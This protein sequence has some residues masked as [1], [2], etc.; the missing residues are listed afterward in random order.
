MNGPVPMDPMLMHAPCGFVS[1][2]D[3]GTL[4]AANATLADWLQRPLDTL[5]GTPL[6]S[7][8]GPGGAIFHQTHF[9]PLL[10]L[11]GEV[12]EIY[13]SLRTADGGTLP[14][15]ANARRHDLPGGAR[16]DCVLVPMRQRHEFEQELVRA[17]E[18]AEAARDAKA[19]FLSMMAHE[20]RSPLS[21]ITGLAHVL[22][23]ELHGP[24]QPEQR[25]DVEIMLRAANDIDQLIGETLRYSRAEA[26]TDASALEAV[27]MEDAFSSVESLMRVRWAEKG[28]EYTRQGDASSCTV[29]AD[30]QRLHQIL[31]NLLGNA[32]KFTPRGGRVSMQCARVE[33][34]DRVRIEVRDTGCGIPADQLERVFEPFVQ[35]ARAGQPQGSRG[36]GLGLA[37]SRE[38]ATSMHGSLHAHSEPGEG[39]VFV[40]TLPVPD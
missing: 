12:R 28:I 1:F 39:T 11:R 31:L 9:F 7:L 21:A 34:E 10:R 6:E 25:E 30:P 40:L 24:L 22:L 8:Y 20:V 32:A 13:F 2:D 3:T 26:G 5:P 4:L 23:Q 15:M 35:L 33:G 14:V 18:A 19:H 37:I 16:T 36:T 17:R 27:S 38:F 29:R